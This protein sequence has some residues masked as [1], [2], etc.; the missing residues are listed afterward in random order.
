MALHVPRP[1]SASTFALAAFATIAALASPRAAIAA[2]P[3]ACLNSDPTQW[4][5]PSKPYFMIAFDTSGSMDQNVVPSTGNTCTFGS[6]GFKRIDHARCA[7]RKTVQAF[8]GQVHFGLTTFNTFM[9][10]CNA[11]TCYNPPWVFGPPQTGCGARFVPGDQNAGC[12]IEPDPTQPFSADRRGGNILVPMQAHD[13]WN[14]P[15]QA[16]NV[17]QMLSYVDNDCTGNIELY[18]GGGTSSNG[19]LRDLFRYFSGSWTST[20]GTRTYTTPLGTA[21]QGERSC[22]SVNIIF[23]TDGDEDCDLEV[24][25]GKTAAEDAAE[26]LLA[27]FTLPGDSIQWK[28]KTYVIRFA[29]GTQATTDKIAAAGGTGTSLF[30]ANE[31]DLSKAFS[32]IISSVIKPETCDNLDNNCNGCTDEGFKHYCNTNPVCCAWA[33]DATRAACVTTY[34]GTITAANPQGDL[35]KLPCATSVQATDPKY[36]VCVNPADV[37]DETDNNCDGTA[38]ENQLKCGSP[39]HCPSAEICDGIDNNCNGAIDEGCPTPCIPSAEVCDGCDNDC[40]GVADNGIAAIPC[41]LIGPGE[42]ANC[43]GVLAC[44][45]PQAVPV[46]GCAAGGGFQACSAMPQTSCA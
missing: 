29:G 20:D 27:G 2:E 24:V 40:D 15:P 23:M 44:N 21:A 7:L 3:A 19:I 16:S 28:I 43:A 12:A 13:Y 32:Q 26:K 25:N 6:T 38:D 8:S 34:Q 45:P 5:E 37:C 30:A 10:G 31:V 41:G 33:D 17:A 14:S 18:A 11:G 46:G 39:A 36:W 35:T 42:P 1:V 4:P 22:R 9:A